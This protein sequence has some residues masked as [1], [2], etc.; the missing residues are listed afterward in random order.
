MIQYLFLILINLALAAPQCPLVFQR[1]FTPQEIQT[2]YGPG[3]AFGNPPMRE[4]LRQLL[5]DNSLS[6]FNK[7]NIWQNLARFALLQ[8]RPFY[9]TY[10]GQMA[11]ALIGGYSKRN[12]RSLLIFV[13]VNQIFASDLPPDLLKLLEPSFN[14]TNL[15]VFDNIPTD[16]QTQAEQ[17]LTQLIFDL[18]RI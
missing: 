8:S 9:F 16:V 1:P 7:I 11:V 5:R 12:W 10:E 3:S 18:N 15:M 4:I 13:G 2:H 6:N 14:K 17:M